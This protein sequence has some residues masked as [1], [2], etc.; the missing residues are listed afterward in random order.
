[1]YFNPVFVS[2]AQTFLSGLPSSYFQ[3]Q[4]SYFRSGV[5][6]YVLVS[7]AN[8]SPSS[9]VIVF[10]F[11][12]EELVFVFSSKSLLVRGHA[13]RG[14]DVPP[15][16]RQNTPPLRAEQVPQVPSCPAVLQPNISGEGHSEKWKRTLREKKGVVCFQSWN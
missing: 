14:Q 4:H 6:D 2:L 5:L 11:H 16:A 12:G 8:Y 7:L 15:P 13:A 9:P 3:Y 10:P 1:M